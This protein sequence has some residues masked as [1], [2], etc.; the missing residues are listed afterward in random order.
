MK[1]FLSKTKAFRTLQE[2]REGK[3]TLVPWVSGAGE[4]AG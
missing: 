2:H 3:E 1:G 4:G